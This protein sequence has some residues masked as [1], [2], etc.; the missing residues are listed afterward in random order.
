MKIAVLIARIL[1]GLVFVFF[2]LNGL[3]P[4]LPNPGL[5][6]GLAG[7]F[8]GVFFAS[9]WVYVI[10]SLQ[11]I[12]GLLVLINRYAVLGLTILAPIIFN[13]L[14]FHILMQPAGIGPGLVVTVLWLFLAW[15]YRQYFDSLFVQ[16][17][18]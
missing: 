2:G 8:I 9:H 12:G 18:Q 6:P 13:I 11:V 15:R 7:Q 3:Y 1:L 5:P 16:R 4:F 17:P 14:T 10:A